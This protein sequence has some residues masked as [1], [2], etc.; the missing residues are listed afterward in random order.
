MFIDQSIG[1]FQDLPLFPL[2]LLSAEEVNPL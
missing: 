1:Q 2:N